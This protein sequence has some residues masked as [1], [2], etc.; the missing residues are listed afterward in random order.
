MTCKTKEKLK[1]WSILVIAALAVTLCMAGLAL[2][3]A[4]A[5][6]EEAAQARIA[7]SVSSEGV[8]HP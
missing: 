6:G 7:S 3:L 1:A 2:P 4:L 8:L 5:G